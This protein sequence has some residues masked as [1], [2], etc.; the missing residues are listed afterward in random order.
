MNILLWKF[1]AGVC[2]VHLWENYTWFDYEFLWFLKVCFYWTRDE[3]KTHMKD[4]SG[5]ISRTDVRFTAKWANCD[6]VFIQCGQ[7]IW[8][9]TVHVSNTVKLR[10]QNAWK[11]RNKTSTQQS[12]EEI[13][14][15]VE[16]W[17]N[18]TF[19]VVDARQR[20]VKL[21]VHSQV[22]IFWQVFWHPLEQTR[23]NVEGWWERSQWMWACFIYDSKKIRCHFTCKMKN[24]DLRFLWW[25]IVVRDQR[26]CGLAWWSIKRTLKIINHWCVEHE[27]RRKASESWNSLIFTLTHT[28]MFAGKA[29][30]EN[31]IKSPNNEHASSLLCRVLIV[32]KR[33]IHEKLL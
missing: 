32:K 17:H 23:L 30:H 7:I 18:D 14:A 15:T 22:G 24:N 3:K 29:F 9:S 19:S 26:K 20:D 10:W 1:N 2:N 5:V 16:V 12:V 13:S 27:I 4:L 25:I 31:S 21:S 8:K 33:E 28:H 6:C 11:A